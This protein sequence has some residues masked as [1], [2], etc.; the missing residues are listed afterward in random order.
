MSQ[1]ETHSDVSLC[2][3]NSPNLQIIQFIVILDKEKLQNFT[4]EKLETWKVSG[5]FGL[6]KN[7]HFINLLFLQI[8]LQILICNVTKT[9]R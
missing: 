7:N 9:D 1:W 4:F 3:T 6:I 8:T 2:P 5:I